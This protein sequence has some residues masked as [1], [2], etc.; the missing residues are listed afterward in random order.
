MKPLVS[1]IITTFNR[2]ELLKKAISSALKQD[3]ENLEVIVSDDGENYEILQNFQDKRLV[4]TKNLTRAKSPNGNK[5]NGFDKANGEYLCLLDDDDELLSG[6]I[7]E[8]MEFIKEGYFSVFA[9]RVCEENGVLTGKISG[10]TPYEKSTKMEK[11]DYHCGKFGGEFFM[12]FSK[13]F[14]ENFRFDESSFGG[15]NELYIRFFEKPTYY[16]KKPLYL[17]RINRDDSATKNA[18]KNG[19]KVANAYIKTIN[20]TKEIALEHN[21]KMIAILYK[22]AAY[23]AKQSGDLKAMRSYLASSLK[24]RVCKENL[25]F[26]SLCFLP[27]FALRWLSS[28]RVKLKKWLKI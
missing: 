5:N 11:I 18:H 7:S 20:L 1:V 2:P 8:C 10:K 28:L 17:Y 3:Y 13:E 25:I 26:L 27:N 15:E 16:Y 22:N 21:P 24:T 23:Y 14:V 4:Y 19:I 12:L 6:T 9:D